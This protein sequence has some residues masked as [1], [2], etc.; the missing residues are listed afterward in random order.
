MIRDDNWIENGRFPVLPDF[1]RIWGLESI[2]LLIA[3]NAYRRY[4]RDFGFTKTL[5]ELARRG[6]FSES[7]LDVFTPG[8][9]KAAAQVCQF[10]WTY[11]EDESDEPPST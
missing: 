4:S 7:E 5:E 9:R 10:G 3:E 1:E 6:G 8:W 11:E 2:P